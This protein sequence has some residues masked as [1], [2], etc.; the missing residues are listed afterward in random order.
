MKMIQGALQAANWM[1][2]VIGLTHETPLHALS[3]HSPLVSAHMV[4]ICH[5]EVGK[6]SDC[7]GLTIQSLTSK[8]PYLSITTYNPFKYGCYL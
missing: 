3:T 1:D 7:R 8:N 4:F 6:V 5:E 2:T